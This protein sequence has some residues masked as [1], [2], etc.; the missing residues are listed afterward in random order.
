[1]FDVVRLDILSHKGRSKW[2]K[3]LDDCVANRF[4]RLTLYCSVLAELF[5]PSKLGCIQLVSFQSLQQIKLCKV[6]SNNTAT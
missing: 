3:P 1:M 5:F 6:L 2:V 4:Q